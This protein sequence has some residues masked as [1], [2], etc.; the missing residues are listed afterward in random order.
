MYKIAFFVPLSHRDEV[1]AAL[2]R[3]G[4]GKMGNY[5]H[6]AWQTEGEGQFKPLQDSKPFMGERDQIERLTEWKVEMVCAE[7]C[8]EAAVKILKEAHPYETVSY[9]VWK[10]ADF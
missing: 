8:I 6:C 4:A 9:D 1:K 5:S 10:L 2:F 3:A 7:D